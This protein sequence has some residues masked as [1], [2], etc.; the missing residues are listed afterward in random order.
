MSHPKIHIGKSLHHDEKL[1]R[2]MG[3][4]KLVCL[5]HERKLYFTPLSHF[6][7]TDPYEGY[8]PKTALH[9]II[10]NL[11]AIRAASVEHIKDEIRKFHD[12]EDN[13][14]YMR[15]IKEYESDDITIVKT[16][17]QVVSSTTVNCWHCNQFESE[18]MW[19]LYSRQGIAIQTSVKSLTDSLHLTDNSLNI[20]IGRVKYLDFNSAENDMASCL[21][22]DGHTLGM[23]KRESY[24]HEKEVRLIASRNFK[25]NGLASLKSEPIM[26]SADVENLI[27]KIYVSPYASTAME[28]CIT[29]ICEKYGIPKEKICKSKLLTGHDELFDIFQNN[30]STKSP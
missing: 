7:E 6:K 19:G 11:Q 29:Y 10:S 27:E 26:I 9:Q 30:P 5:L 16:V 1:W 25:I 2:Y 8:I 28:N 23:I 15:I 3:I 17:Q 22:D 21:T 12:Y 13:P 14:E 20:S 24:A 4:E 18:A